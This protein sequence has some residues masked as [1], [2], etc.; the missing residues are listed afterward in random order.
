MFSLGFVF[1]LAIGLVQGDICA[2]VLTRDCAF[3]ATFSN[4]CGTDG[5]TYRNNC[6]LARAYCS[7]NTIHKAHEGPCATP[8]T[9][10]SPVHGSQVA[11]DIFCLDLIYIKC[12]AGGSQICGSDGTFYDNICEFDKARCFHRDLQDNGTNCS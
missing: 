12:P 6:F 7:D 8:T 10:P 3:V 4:V 9:T 11:L 5:T 2:Y 1:I